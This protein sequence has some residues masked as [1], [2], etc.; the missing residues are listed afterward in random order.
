[1][2]TKPFFGMEATRDLEKKVGSDTVKVGEMEI[3]FLFSMMAIPEIT[4]MGKESQNQPV[5][6]YPGTSEINRMDWDQLEKLPEG[7]V[8][9]AYVSFAELIESKDVEA[10]FLEKELDLLWLGVDTGLDKDD[11][12]GL[13]FEP[14]GFP[15]Y[16]IWHEDDMT[17]ESQQKGGN[18]F[19]GWESESSSS[20]TYNHGDQ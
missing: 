18:W 1:T 13:I 19:F 12:H 8:V 11:S 9:S 5:F 2:N 6:Y 15:S 7:T 3:N 16:P 4:S 20:P 14:I 17:I 10:F